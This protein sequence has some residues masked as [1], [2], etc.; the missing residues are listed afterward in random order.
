MDPDKQVGIVGPLTV[1]PCGLTQIHQSEIASRGGKASS[2]KFKPG[3]E[4][5][6]EAGRKGGKASGSSDDDV[7]VEDEE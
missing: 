6:R 3:D 1:G 7:D 5:A 4:R 2:G